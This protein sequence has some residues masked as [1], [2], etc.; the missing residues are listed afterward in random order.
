MKKIIISLIL[1]SFTIVVICL[2]FK[3]HYVSYNSYYK[4]PNVER[5][6]YSG[7]YV[8]FHSKNELKS[9]FDLNDET[10][11]FMEN[12]KYIN[13]NF[14]KYSYLIVYGAK[15]DKMYYS[16]KTTWFDDPSPSY[17]KARRF[18]KKCVFIKYRKVD[19][20]VYFYQIKKDTL[21]TGFNGL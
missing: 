4:I 19:K 10:H 12:S 6:F 5:D 11:K 8:F 21:L 7:A 20:A 9:F 1:L 16:Y 14:S 3:K 2:F 17:A 15:I 18:G 13:F